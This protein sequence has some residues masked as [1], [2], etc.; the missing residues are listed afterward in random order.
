MKTKNQFCRS[1]PVRAASVL[2]LLLFWG[3]AALAQDTAAELR[4]FISQQVGG[5]NSN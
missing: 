3:G 1:V 2:S 5:L 4:A